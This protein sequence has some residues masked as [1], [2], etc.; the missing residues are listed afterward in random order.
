MTVG[1]TLSAF[2]DT[3]E[4]SALVLGA[5]AA[6][7]LRC[8]VAVFP[9]PGE[10]T[11]PMFGDFE[12]QRHWMEITTALPARQWYENS[13]DNDLLYWGLD[14]PPLTAYHSLLLGRVGNEF[15]P[16]C[17]ALGASRGHESPACRRFMR[18]SAI[19]SDV[20]VYFPGTY[21]AVWGFSAKDEH[22]AGRVAAILAFWLLPPLVLIDHG[23]FQFNGVCFGLCLAAAGCVARGHRL[24]ASVLFT[25]GL[26]FK[27]IALYYAPAFFFGILAVCIRQSDGLVSGVARVAV[28]GM[29]VLATAACLFAPW[30]LGSEPLPAVLQVIHR[31]FPFT[32]GLYEDKVANVWCSISIVFKLGRY[33]PA[34]LVPAVCAAATLAA[35]LP[36]NVACLWSSRGAVG[37]GAV[38]AA[39]LTASSFSFFLFAF[40]VHEKSVLFPCLA[41]LL[42][43]T[44]LGPKRRPSWAPAALCH[45]AAA[46]LYSMYPLI[47]K[48][49]LH[50]PYALFAVLLIA[51]FECLPAPP[52][53]LRL[54][55]RMSTAVGLVLH[56][57]HAV[58]QAPARYPDA[59]TLLITG[60]SCGYFVLCLLALTAMQLSGW[61]LLGTEFADGTAGGGRP[62]KE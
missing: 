59:W 32:R 48:D 2:C 17:F 39:A 7:V 13:T 5:A 62:K 46:C 57:V 30:L 36:A 51:L 10:A 60:S 44:A 54:F 26:L 15:V 9:Y 34:R 50:L 37:V 29:V 12:A 49:K 20:L 47:V 14:Y 43:P 53:L 45:F 25:S 11:P 6:V 16:V 52:P 4:S 8:A 61:G 18:A 24:V 27:Q 58:L 31:M 19:A 38:F 33:V 3:H 21:C 28:T 42:L 22:A 35:L 41:A 55:C 56:I 40:Q 1:N 23:H